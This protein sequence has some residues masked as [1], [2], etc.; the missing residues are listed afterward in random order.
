MKNLKLLPEH[1]RDDVRNFRWHCGCGQQGLC[2]SV[3]KKGTIQ[4]HCFTCGTTVFWNDPQVFG[5]QD[6]FAYQKEM[7]KRKKM[8]GG[9]Y[10]YWYP[11][12]RVRVFKP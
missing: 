3:T 8:K 7:P 9:G 5:F 2:V 11:K 1:I 10:S 4:G 12:H 6:P